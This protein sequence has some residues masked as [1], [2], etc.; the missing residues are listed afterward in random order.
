M[1]LQNIQDFSKAIKDSLSIMGLDVGAKKIGIAVGSKKLHIASPV[2][3]IPNNKEYLTRISQLI[4]E[5][6]I[7]GIVVG[8]P[9]AMDG[10]IKEQAKKVLK[11]S[12]SLERFGLPIFHHDERMSTKMAHSIMQQFD[13][14]RKIRD[15]KDDMLAASIML[16]G[17]FD[18]MK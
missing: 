14:S 7:G 10:E 3:I 4:K 17:F 6:E 1:I 2:T 16:Q 12:K 5:W 18:S 9:L 13:V 8:L 11:F 15:V